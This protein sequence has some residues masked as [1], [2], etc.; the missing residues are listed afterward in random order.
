MYMATGRCI[1]DKLRVIHQGG[2]GTVTD[3]QLALFHNI[4]IQGTRLTTI[5]ARSGLTK[6][7]MIELVN[8]CEKNDFVRRSPDPCDKRAKIVTLTRSGFRL[9]ETLKAGIAF[10]ENEIEK[11]SGPSF[12]EEMRRELSMYV[13][14][15]SSTDK[16]DF[17]PSTDRTNLVVRGDG[18]GRILSLAARHFASCTLQHAHQNGYENVKEVSLALFR[19]LDVGGSRLTEVAARARMTKQSMR[20]LVERAAIQGYVSREREAGDGRAKLITFTPAGLGLLDQLRCGVTEAE[21]DFKRKTG[22]DFVV[23]LDAAL[24]KY[25]H[26]EL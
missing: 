19:N 18:T 5:A 22:R 3:A 13:V 17:T 4:D 25:I 9:V 10:S 8:K 6:Q 14:K 24:T 15:F 20:E 7:S 26:A 21:K 16:M 12:L 2:F 1:R 11:V 23:R